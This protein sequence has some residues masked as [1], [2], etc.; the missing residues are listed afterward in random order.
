[1]KI[2]KLEWDR[3]VYF[4]IEADDSTK[5]I[6]SRRRKIHGEPDSVRRGFRW[7]RAGVKR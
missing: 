5:G 6:R 3:W 1:L 4:A 2:W 7:C